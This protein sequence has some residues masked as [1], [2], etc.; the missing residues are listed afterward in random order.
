MRTGR[1][2]EYVNRLTVT[3]NIEQDLYDLG[4]DQ[5]EIPACE[6]LTDGYIGKIDEA[7]NVRKDVNEDTLDY[8]FSIRNR[9]VKDRVSEF[10]AKQREL[11]RVATFS[12]EVRDSIE[13][14]SQTAAE[15]RQEQELKRAEKLYVY[16][17][18][19]G[20]HRIIT[21]EQYDA[22]PDSYTILPKPDFVKEDDS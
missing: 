13:K 3:T 8:Y 12:G 5:F 17:S 6:A 16:D 1:P 14:A 4:K 11:K 10:K 21:R 2:R 9:I 15:R 18:G 22:D 20:D 7:I 19:F